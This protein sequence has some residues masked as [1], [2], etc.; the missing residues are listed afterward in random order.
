MD[1]LDVFLAVLASQTKHM[2]IFE[3]EDISGPG[4]STPPLHHMCT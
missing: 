4:G 1:A 3:F 2:Y